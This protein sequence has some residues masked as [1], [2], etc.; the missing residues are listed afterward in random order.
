M[1]AC[2]VVEVLGVRFHETV[3]L[4]Q[5]TAQ[6]N[7]LARYSPIRCTMMASRGLCA[8][9]A[10][11][12][13]QG[14]GSGSVAEFFGGEV[15]RPWNPAEV[16][17]I[18]GVPVADFQAELKR[19]L[20]SRP[21]VVSDEQWAHTR[22]LYAA[23]GHAPLWLDEN[24]LIEA[25]GRALVD[26]LVSATGDAI[27]LDQYPLVEL[28]AA[29]DSVRRVDQ[30][31]PALLAR[32]DL[33][34]TTSF[35]SLGEDYLTGQVDPKS[36][37]Q[38]WHIT[39]DE[40]AVDSALSRSLRDENLAEAIGR[41]RPQ[42]FDYEML[43]R[44]LDDYRRVV[45]AGGWPRVP[46]GKPL[47]RGDSDSPERMNALR[48]RL[49][50]EGFRVDSSTTYTPALAAAIA[51]FQ[52]RHGIVV[53]SMLGKET[54]DAL[55]VSADY[56]LAQIAANLERYRWMPRVLG[57]RYVFVN[58]PAFRLTA[59]DSGRKTLEMKVIVGAEY[60]GRATPVFSDRMEFVVFRPYWNVTD[61][62]AQNELFPKFARTGVPP[63]YE[64]YTENGV[65]RIRQK[66]G[67][68]NSLGLVKF[69]FPNNFNI[70]LH[71]T[72]QPELFRKDVRAFSH[73]C[74]RVE[75]PR[76][77]A[78]WVLGWPADRV[79]AAMHGTNNRHVPLPRKIPVYIAYFTTYVRDGRLW[80]GNDLYN[81]DD[82]LAV[83]VSRGAM[84]SAQAVRA[85]AALRELTD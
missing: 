51:E 6:A 54:L 38:N 25:R 1:D 43:R 84:P 69:M 61:N 33:L 81:R 60:D 3:E 21:R 16:A 24:G 20:E 27:S 76:E 53:D 68:N 42:D 66:P 28:A 31:S 70:Y 73:G 2:I 63:D 82:R 8:A 10:A 57:E 48:A 35:V 18:E 36:M 23:Y 62:I 65:Q 56:R 45:S 80:F 15:S 78:Q 85:V 67:E 49:R 4:H 22:N 30:P 79:E 77:L 75:K 55:N 64:V 40:S 72:P 46:E 13:I 83:A 52:A 5:C 26:A 37:H 19:Q 58:V 39:A 44:H 41:M 29:L 11:L 50:A 74:I 9:V 47:K 71:D 17:T 7:R 14:C 59:F 32:A 12:L 34:L